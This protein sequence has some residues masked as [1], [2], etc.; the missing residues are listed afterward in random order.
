MRLSC[1]NC[2]AQYEVPNEVVPQSGRDVQ[3]SNCGHT[4][5]QAHPDSIEEEAAQAADPRVDDSWDD[6]LAADAPDLPPEFEV[7][8]EIQPPAMNFEDES[9]SLDVTDAPQ[10]AS[11]DKA[12][13]SHAPDAPSEDHPVDGIDKD[14]SEHFLDEDVDTVSAFD[15]LLEEDAAAPVRERKTIDPEIADLLREEAALEAK[16][17]A[18][19]NT[20]ESQPDLGLADPEP[21]LDSR[22]VQAQA[23]MNRLRG[24]DTSDAPEIPT[25]APST[26]TTDSRRQLLPDIEEINSTLRSTDERYAD[27]AARVGTPSGSR[28]SGFRLGFGLVLLAAALVILA[29][30]YNQ[31]LAERFPAYQPQITQFM[32]T[33][34]DMRLW[35]DTRVTN[36]MLWLNEQAGT[37]TGTE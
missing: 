21:V 13:M 30:V 28:Q 15:T 5:F 33:M 3:C 32:D 34:N 22:A 37:S 10:N 24:L 17:R 29:Y 18:H 20:L 27:D 31:A 23:R 25:T 7:Q 14:I 11:G 35:L 1:P 6:E 4:W 36:M 16:L 19:E 26:D 9:D 2:D 8:E 12:E